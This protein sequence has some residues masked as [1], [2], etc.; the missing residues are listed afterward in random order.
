ME[1]A[2][3]AALKEL[4]AQLT[5]Q[6]SQRW[7]SFFLDRAKPCPFFVDAPDENLA[8]WIRDGRVPAGRAIELG[9]GHA[10]NAIFL[11]GSGFTVDAVDHSRTAIAWAQERVTASGA[12][13]SLI[14]ASVFDLQLPRGGYD[15]VYDSGC[16]HHIAPHR[17]TQYVDL[18]VR[19][20]KPGG[21]LGL[22]CFRPEGGSGYSDEDVYRHGS[23]GGGLGYAEEQL[24]QIWSRGLRVQVLRPMEKPDAGS[25]LFGETLLWV[26][27]AQKT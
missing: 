12:A 2:T 19:A 22:T 6:D 23:L 27:L 26:L 15:F 25:G 17:R 8:Q 7:D 10:R 13:V 11:A 9:C 24:R 1:H 16:F 14:H 18:V 5:G 3:P 20:L 4:D 21:R